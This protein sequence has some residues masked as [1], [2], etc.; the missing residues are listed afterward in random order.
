MQRRTIDVAVSAAGL[1]LA[2]VLIVFGVYFNDRYQFANNNVRDQLAEQKI[3]FPPKAQLSDEEREQPG[4]VKYAGQAVNDGDKA[5]VYANQ[6]IGLHLKGIGEGTE[7]EGK[8]Y[9][10]L[11]G[12]VFALQ[13][14]LAAAEESGDTVAA[15]EIESK[16]GELR[17]IRD[18][19]LTGETLRGL[20]LTTYGFWQFGQEAQLATYVSFAAAAILFLL[21]ALG[22]FHAV[23]TRPGVELWPAEAPREEKVPELV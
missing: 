19:V 14:E 5:Q 12:P 20:L 6:F 3:S 7:Y 23:R 10:E 16:L 21:A 11:G 17:G 4:L 9:A 8:T 15:A 13:D 22:F 18:T 1:V 2:V